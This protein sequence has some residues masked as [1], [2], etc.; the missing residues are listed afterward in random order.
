M[1]EPVTLEVVKARLGIASNHRD[2]ELQDLVSAAR[3]RV[4]DYTG[5]V[6]TR[7]VVTQYPARFVAGRG[8]AVNAWPIVS[9]DGVHYLDAAGVE[10]EFL[11]ARLVN[12]LQP[13]RVFAPVGLSWPVTGD[14]PG[15]R[16]TFT[17]GY[18][19]AA[20]AGDP[21]AVPRQ[22]ITALLLLVGHWFEN[23]EAVVVGT[24]AVE[25]PMGV[26]DICS[27]FRLPGIL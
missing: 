19:E 25:L 23:H 9:L 17:A 16:M 21:D 3:E 2:A 13:A 14:P 26:R 4:E 7:R 12:G 15:I 11:G 22:L 20:A 5:H 8:L 27:D 1:P 18:D 24:S 10:Q 6:L